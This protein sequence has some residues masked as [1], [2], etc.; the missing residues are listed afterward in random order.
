MFGVLAA[1]AWLSQVVYL[2]PLPEQRI[3]RYMQVH[4]KAFDSGSAPNLA[5][6]SREVYLGRVRAEVSYE[7][8][9]EWVVSLLALVFGLFAAFA[10]I[11]QW[12]G[13]VLVLMISSVTY[14][15]IWLVFSGVIS[16]NLSLAGTF[17]DMWKAS[18]SLGSE[19]VFIHRDI[20]LLG[21]FAII[22]IAT[23]VSLVQG[24]VST[25]RKNS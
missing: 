5:S 7:F 18:R 4:A 8:W 15:L 25:R 14:V 13:S 22:A 20:V 11:R 10:A 2:V 6:E 9:S 21:L 16:S 19:A 12:R 1:V 24:A 17:A 23:A 3:D